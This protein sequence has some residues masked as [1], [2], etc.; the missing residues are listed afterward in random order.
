MPGAGRGHGR[1]G[2]GTG[3]LRSGRVGKA[4][5]KGGFGQMGQKRFTGA[6]VKGALGKERDNVG[7][8]S[9]SKKAEF[10]E[11]SAAR[12]SSESR[13]AIGKEKPHTKKRP[14]S[15]GKKRSRRDSAKSVGPS[16]NDEHVEGSSIVLTPPI[17]PESTKADGSS[18]V[19]N[20]PAPSGFTIPPLKSSEESPAIP[21][22]ISYSTGLHVFT[23]TRED[24]AM[25]SPGDRTRL[26]KHMSGV[27][28]MDVWGNG[29]SVYC[30]VEIKD[31]DLKRWLEN[32]R[33]DLAGWAVE[34]IDL[35]A[36]DP[37][38]FVDCGRSIPKVD[39]SG[40]YQLVVKVDVI[41]KRNLL[42]AMISNFNILKVVHG[43]GESIIQVGHLLELLAYEE[44]LK[45]AFDVKKRHSWECL[46][47]E[48]LDKS[49]PVSKS[50]LWLWARISRTDSPH[51]LSAAHEQYWLHHQ[52]HTAGLEVLHLEHRLC[53][54]NNNFLIVL[55]LQDSSQQQVQAALDGLGSQFKFLEVSPTYLPEKLNP[56]YLVDVNGFYTVAGQLPSLSE[57]SKKK[58]GED[59]RN[60]GAVGFKADD[61]NPE[62]SSFTLHF[63]NSR[64]LDR[65]STDDKFKNFNLV[66]QSKKV[67]RDK[68]KACPSSVPTVVSKLKTSPNLVPSVI[69]MK[70]IKSLKGAGSTDETNSDESKLPSP[71]KVSKLV[72][73]GLNDRE[74]DILKDGKT[75]T[76][77]NKD[78]TLKEPAGKFTKE[79][80]VS[81]VESSTKSQ[82]DVKSDKVD[83][84]NNSSNNPASL[85]EE[86]VC[87]ET[88]VLSEKE[89][90][91]IHWKEE[92]TM[93]KRL[94]CL[95]EFLGKFP[96]I[97]LGECN[98]VVFFNFK[99]SSKLASVLKE[100][101]KEITNTCDKLKG[102]AQSLHVNAS[103]LNPGKFGLIVPNEAYPQI[104]LEYFGKGK[105][106][107]E[108]RSSCMVLW[109]STKYGMFKAF[110]EKL[111]KV[112]YSC[113]FCP[114]NFYLAGMTDPGA[115][116][117]ANVRGLNET[118]DST[119]SSA[120]P[121]K[122]DEEEIFSFSWKTER[123]DKSEEKSYSRLM[124][125]FIKTL[126]CSSLSASDEG[127]VAT[128][129]K[130]DDVDS[131]LK[132]Y[133]RNDTDSLEKLEGKS[134]VFSFLPFRGAFGL[135]SVKRVKPEDFARFGDCR[136]AGS[137]IWFT[138]KL[139]LVQALRDP[140]ILRTY[141]AL[142]IDCRNIRVL[143]KGQINRLS[144]PN[145]NISD[146]FKDGEE[147][148]HDLED[149][150]V[151]SV[152]SKGSK[153]PKIDSPLSVLFPSHEKFRKVSST[154][155]AKLIS[156]LVEG[157]KKDEDVKNLK[158]AKKD[159]VELYLKDKLGIKMIENLVN[160][161]DESE[162]PKNADLFEPGKTTNSS[163]EVE[164]EREE[165]EKNAFIYPDE[166][167]RLKSPSFSKEESKKHDSAVKGDS[168]SEEVVMKKDVSFGKTDANPPE[169]CVLPS[170]LNVSVLAIPF[171]VSEVVNEAK[172]L[173]DILEDCKWFSDEVT[174]KVEGVSVGCKEV[175]VKFE[176]VALL[177]VV[178]EGLGTT[179]PSMYKRTKQEIVADKNGLYSLVF[180]DEDKLGYAA[181][182][183]IFEKYGKP[184]I[185]KGSLRM[186]VVISFV[187]EEEAL[188][189]LDN[190]GESCAKLRPL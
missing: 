167:I 162:P 98:G 104:R 94:S 131:A 23:A 76:N 30:G 190:C 67:V 119:D 60:I 107:V 61:S 149:D 143:E 57:E 140:F 32:A 80:K 95:A 37:Y 171:Q 103:T 73:G 170:S 9:V 29:E 102:A 150:A 28:L 84:S 64:C 124:T 56:S 39:G 182:K 77:G 10:G 2:R 169:E 33:K 137:S 15:K 127:L 79:R 151:V 154:K 163:Q 168:S 174:V 40:L 47:Q 132:K 38:K 68:A 147:L 122:L 82:V 101:C 176:D 31:G 112:S 44:V 50:E 117:T 133:C 18:D 78:K 142:W 181:T 111:H 69:K 21:L 184:I 108:N 49:S 71:L 62:S 116:G 59:M 129:L 87:E 90:L 63:V 125:T 105:A 96:E 172:F 178:L 157:S 189:A 139:G 144:K 26:V 7:E 180:L 173:D 152:V 118:G 121:F 113:K 155:A 46:P 99:D 52:L 159:R 134:K 179:Y 164:K 14:K 75:A 83:S 58:F 109:F 72:K 36:K 158:E 100:S 123:K 86:E 186:E 12:N 17:T 161:T 175:L 110:V 13:K 106:F 81:S 97:E 22:N 188:A 5:P 185:K 88:A 85:V 1:G 91:S 156:S 43:T 42:L 3:G 34:P 51:Q 11:K 16:R 138:S 55:S 6:G 145:Q 183:A 27:V 19:N 177:E 141:P 114:N 41:Q 92:A 128:F 24:R 160:P 120:T 4:G 74:S 8:E 25:V 130:K 70:E 166:D 135:F 65:I 153:F 136:I 126:K 115:S 48:G 35:Q 148:F 165:F 54:A 93:Q 45:S 20:N 187:T 146:K 89:L 53:G 66:T